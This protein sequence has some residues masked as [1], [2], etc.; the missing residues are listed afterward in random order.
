MKPSPHSVMRGWV[1]H[2]RLTPRRHAFRYRL[3]MLCL[4]L[5]QLES[6]FAGRWLWSLER[7]NVASFQSRDHLGGETTDLAAKIRDL[8]ESETGKR[9]DGRILLLTQPR[10][11]GYVMNPISLFLCHDQQGQLQAIV[12]E[13]HNTPWGERHPYVLPVQDPQATEIRI[14]FD[15]AM[16]VSPFMS[17]D[18]RYRLQ[19]RRND[20]DLSLGLENYQNGQRIFSANMTL[21]AEPMNSR[22]LAYALAVTPF[23]TGKIVAAI[24]WEALRLWLKRIPYIPHP[25]NSPAAVQQDQRPR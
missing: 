6:A 1:S 18:I 9:P 22:S 2:L 3:S 13:V 21:T 20:N 25:G 5:D 7:A 19:L 16:H 17:M 4:D 10:Y 23:M 15:K 12:A 14:D 24:Y 11:F 8:V